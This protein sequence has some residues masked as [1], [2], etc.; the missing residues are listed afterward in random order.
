M[1]SISFEQ[2]TLLVSNLQPEH[3]AILAEWVTFDNRSDCWRA[4][5]LDYRSIVMMLHRQ[6]IP[7]QDAAKE[8]QH[9]DL[10]HVGEMT[11]RYYQQQAL[12]AWWK[13]GGCGVVVMPTGS[14]KSFLAN[15]CM[16]KVK[17]S[18]LVVVP[19]IDLMYQWVNQLEKFFNRKIGM[20]GGGNKDVQDIT[21]ST[22]DSAVIQMEYIG[23]RFGFVVFD[24]CHHLPGPVN[25]NSALMSIAPFRLGITATPERNDGGEA[26]LYELLGHLAYRIEIDQLEGKVLSP[27][28]TVRFAVGLD[29]DEQEQY[30]YYR[31]VYTD[32]LK[33][34]RIDFSR[35]GWSQFIIQSC[36]QPGG[37]EALKAFMEQKRIARTCR[38]KFTKIWE[39]LVLHAGERIIVFTADNNTAY[40]LGNRFLMPV[41][42]HHT[43]GA[44]RKRF[45][46]QF[47]SGDYK[48]LITS[49]VLNEG[50]DVPEASVG[51]V[52]SGTG[53][54]REHVQRLGRI[55]RPSKNKQAVLYELISEGTSEIYVS[56]RRRQHRAYYR[57]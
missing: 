27:Y 14:G 26:V 16:L 44:E 20:L 45:L 28:E 55:L 5:A 10:K 1:I 50:V 23:N 32:F 13:S 38:S 15:L 52:V 53:S 31:K 35:D 33:R 41:I 57:K 17:R 47:R 29:K 2:G 42:T 34:A 6:K 39:I 48:V 46:D 30:D 49:K 8:F 4:K 25:R 37:K 51:I 19:T 40:E 54:T 12:D 36:R 24:E 21:V 7:Y 11:P 3:E 22:Y 56:E 9:I 43:K 18:T